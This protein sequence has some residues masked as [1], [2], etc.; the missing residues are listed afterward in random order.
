LIAV[1]GV[2]FVAVVV[3]RTRR[4]RQAVAVGDVRS[5]AAARAS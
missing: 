3:R 5:A 2:L 1:V 4:F